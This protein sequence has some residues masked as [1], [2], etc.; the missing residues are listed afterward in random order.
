MFFFNK[1]KVIPIANWHIVLWKYKWITDNRLHLKR[2]NCFSCISNSFSSTFILFHNVVNWTHCKFV[3][4]HRQHSWEVS[5][6][7][8]QNNPIKVCPVGHTQGRE[9]F[10]WCPTGQ[11]VVL[12]DS[13]CIIIFMIVGR[14]R[15]GICNSEHLSWGGQLSN[16]AFCCGNLV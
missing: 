14:I 8:V 11:T 3:L 6:P 16:W 13:S 1:Y 7:A 12:F 5:W 9:S 4:G 2:L 15:C 10:H